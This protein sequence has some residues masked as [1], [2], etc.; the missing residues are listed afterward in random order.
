M[1]AMSFTLTFSFRAMSKQNFFNVGLH[2]T[3]QYENEKTLQ[4]IEDAEKNLKGK[5]SFI[6]SEKPENPG[7]P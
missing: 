4:R 7:K 6:Y 2:G 5:C 1:F 3:K